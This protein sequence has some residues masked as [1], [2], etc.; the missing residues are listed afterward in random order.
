M[1]SITCDEVDRIVETTVLCDVHVDP[2]V[3]ILS[4]VWTLAVLDHQVAL[5]SDLLVAI[6]HDNHS[7]LVL[8]LAHLA[9]TEDTACVVIE[10]NSVVHAGLER[11]VVGESVDHGVVVSL[12][13]LDVLDLVVVRLQFDL[14]LAILAGSPGVLLERRRLL[15]LHQSSRLREKASFAALRNAVSAVQDPLL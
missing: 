13:L 12:D 1:D 11:S 14:A 10:S 5:V 3:A 4:K 9:V 8:T 6:T 7:L 2:Q 15:E